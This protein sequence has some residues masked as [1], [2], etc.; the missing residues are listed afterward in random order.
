MADDNEGWKT[1]PRCIALPVFFFLQVSLKNSESSCLI[2]I[3]RARPS[4][5]L[6]WT[7]IMRLAPPPL[8]KRL[9]T[10]IKSCNCDSSN[11]AEAKNVNKY[12][13]L[14]FFLLFCVSCMRMWARDPQKRWIGRNETLLGGWLMRIVSNLTGRGDP[15]L[16]FCS[17][18]RYHTFMYKV[19][20]CLYKMLGNLCI[21][22]KPYEK[23]HITTQRW[24]NTIPQPVVLDFVC[25]FK[26][27]A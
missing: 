13:R 20:A 6:I 8:Y 24:L 1:A 16:N 27:M 9:F 2:I 17:P 7:E 4:I 22:R 23:V 25:L 10:I 21:T 19:S 26:R 14:I 12:A 15:L 18:S 3:W 5:F 11:A